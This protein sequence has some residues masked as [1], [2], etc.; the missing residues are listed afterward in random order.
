MLKFDRQRGDRSSLLIT[1]WVPL[2]LQ[3]NRL[4]AA[5]TQENLET[6]ELQLKISP[7]PFLLASVRLDCQR[8]SPV[9]STL[10]K[11]HDTVLPAR[12]FTPVWSN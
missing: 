4:G 10:P 7:R 1:S 12:T 9:S 11:I 8:P 2:G 6:P 5:A 3:S